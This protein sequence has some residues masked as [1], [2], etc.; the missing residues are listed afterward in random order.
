MDSNIEKIQPAFQNND[1]LKSF[2]VYHQSPIAIELYDSEGNILDINQAGKDLF[3]INDISQLKGFNLFADPNLPQ[4]AI[5]DIKEGKSIRYEFPFDFE[6]VKARKL[7]ETT[8]SGLCYLEC[9]IHPTNGNS[10]INGYIVHVFEITERKKAERE[11]QI[12]N[13]RMRSFFDSNI[14][15]VVIATPDGTIVETNDYYLNLIGYSREEYEAGK[16]NWRELTPKEWLPVDEKALQELRE[17]GMCKTYEKEYQLRDG[18]R[19]PVLITDAMLPG[20]E[21]HIVGFILNISARKAAE[22]AL[23]KSEEKFRQIVE[24]S[25]RGMYFYCLEDNDRLVFI[26]SN[27]AADK[28][29]GI[30][31][32]S[33]IGKTI[34]EAFPNLADTEIPDR[35]KRIARGECGPTQFDIEYKDE[36]V[37][38]YY[39]VH[40]FLTEKNTITVN[41]TDI[42]RHKQTEAILEKQ[43]I[44]LKQ[45]NATKDKF[46]SIIAHDLK[47]PFN[48]IIGFSDLM[49]NN[50]KQLDEETLFKGL[51]TI[52]SAS[53]QAYKLLENL[54]IW[55]QNQTGRL[56]FN[57]EILNLS[58]L[59]FDSF[60]MIESTAI[61]KD[62]QISI[63]INKSIQVV[64]D[65]NM[66][67]TIFRNLLTNA[68]KFTPRGGKVKIKASQFDGEVQISVS[69]TGIGMSAEK[70]KTIFE[71]DKLTNTTGTEDE[72][73]SG[74]GLIL[75]KDFLSIHKGKIWVKSS[76]GKGSRFTFS[77]PV[78]SS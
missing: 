57:P 42:S 35:Y 22:E 49:L 41:F 21:E 71:I 46:F 43:A 3:G 61:R 40:V 60:T 20:T 36:K 77:L 32:F 54:L 39:D 78:L 15:G 50:F 37:S 33:L 4:Q 28:I 65:K 2:D 30:N 76:P 52:E 56:P 63:Q 74:L 7:Y 67:D 8:K 18:R 59:A 9:F 11:I 14:A 34:E 24:C 66:I 53:T 23:R 16:V 68:I 17:T 19:I 69:D 64:A 13:A 25:T 58:D 44:E 6:L 75:C 51:K 27:P 12:S 72:Q 73:G 62:I 29:I 55:S 38:G 5:L 47:N 26:G 10:Q 70:Q 1:Y 48:A 45:L 31:H